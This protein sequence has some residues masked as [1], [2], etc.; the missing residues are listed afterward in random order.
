M[1]KSVCLDFMQKGTVKALLLELDILVI[2]KVVKNKSLE[3]N[4]DKQKLKTLYFYAVQR[5]V[6][7]KAKIKLMDFQRKTYLKVSFACI[8]SLF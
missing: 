4:K 3:Q 7:D 8:L 6:I 5:Y 1:R 2:R